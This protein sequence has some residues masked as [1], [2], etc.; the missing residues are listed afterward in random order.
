MAV[1]QPSTTLVAPQ[2]KGIIDPSTGKPIGSN[3]AF[4]GEIN[5]EERGVGAEPV[6]LA[7]AVSGATACIEDASAKTIRERGSDILNKLIGHLLLQTGAGLIGGRSPVE[8]LPH[9]LRA[10]TQGPV[11]VER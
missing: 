10:H 2:P 9:R 7:Q 4:F 8:T 5:T 1:M 11:K 6:Q 3:A